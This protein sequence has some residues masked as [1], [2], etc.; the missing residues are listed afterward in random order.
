MHELT[1]T[2]IYSPRLDKIAFRTERRRG[3]VVE[4]HI[5]TS[6]SDRTY[7]VRLVNPGFLQEP[8]KAIADAPTLR[9]RFDASCT[10]LKIFSDRGTIEF[11]GDDGFH[12]SIKGTGLDIA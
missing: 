4:M 12:H 8:Y 7:V 10:L 2:E 9:A 6:M 11:W 5:S 1:L 3:T